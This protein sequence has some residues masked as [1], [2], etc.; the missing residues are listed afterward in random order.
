MQ[1]ADLASKF[2]AI[3][4][5]QAEVNLH[6][7]DCQDKLELRV[8]ELEKL[9]RL[10]EVEIGKLESRIGELETALTLKDTEIA[11]L[12]ATNQREITTLKAR[13]TELESENSKQKD[14][15][16]KLIS[17]IEALQRRRK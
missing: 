1:N 2:Q 13:V 7:E 17:E 12:K 11:N 16:A 15:N 3:A 6:L 5:K 14:E 8:E 9:L 4:I 10:K